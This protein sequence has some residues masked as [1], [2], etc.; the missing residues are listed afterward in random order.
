VKPVVW[1]AVIFLSQGCAGSRFVVS[2]ADIWR[3]GAALEGKYVQIVETDTAPKLSQPAATQFV[4]SCQAAEEK[5]RTRFRAAHPQ[6]KD[7]GRRLGEKFELH[8]GCTVRM[9]FKTE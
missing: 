4:S 7:E 2:D 1:A 8:A 9:A 3:D 6:S 5:A